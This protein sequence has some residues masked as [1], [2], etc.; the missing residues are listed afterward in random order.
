MLECLNAGR[1]DNAL[2]IGRDGHDTLYALR[3]RRSRAATSITKADTALVA[4][5]RDIR[6]GQHEALG[7][8]SANRKMCCWPTLCGRELEDADDLSF[9]SLTMP[10]S[11]GDEEHDAPRRP[12][13]LLGI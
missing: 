1:G 7:A 10:R 8:V 12:Q 9:A 4:K 11:K 3:M 5:A 6:D 2:V 13:R